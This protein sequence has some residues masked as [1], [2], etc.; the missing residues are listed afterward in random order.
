MMIDTWNRDEM[1]LNLT[2]PPKFVPGPLPRHSLAKADASYSGLLEC[3]LTTRVQKI[4]Y[5]AYHVQLNGSCS[6]EIASETECYAA[7]VQLKPPGFQVNISTVSTSSIP[8][9]CS[10]ELRDQ[11]L[12]TYFNTAG[13][14]KDCNQTSTRLSGADTALITLNVTLDKDSPNATITLTGPDGVWF[15]AGFGVAAMAGEP[16]TIIVDGEGKVTE[17]K[18]QNHLPGLSKF[19]SYFCW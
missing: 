19:F 2:N 10:V 5:D 1:P 9:N 8:H 17:R 6:Y 14:G 4:L 13:G 15:G 11:T 18:L 7:A 3:P 12:F 16:W